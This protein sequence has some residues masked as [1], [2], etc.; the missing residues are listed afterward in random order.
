ML[1]VNIY[2]YNQQI[3]EIF[4]LLSKINIFVNKTSTMFSL[5]PHENELVENVITP[6]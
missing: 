2:E 1:M 3:Q 5:R 4:Q 6:I